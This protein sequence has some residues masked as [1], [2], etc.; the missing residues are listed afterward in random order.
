MDAG[1]ATI[2]G[3]SYDEI[4]YEM[5]SMLV[6]VGWRK[7]FSFRYFKF[8]RLVYIEKINSVRINDGGMDCLAA[9]LCLN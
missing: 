3:H 1:P 6:K 5:K 4:A 8:S 7:Y 2:K 9:R